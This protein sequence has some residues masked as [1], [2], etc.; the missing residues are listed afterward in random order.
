MNQSQKSKQ[1]QRDHYRLVEQHGPLGL[2]ILVMTLSLSACG[3]SE[4]KP[5]MM[6]ASLSG[7]TA[8]EVAGEAAGEVAGEAAGEVAGEA[9]GEVAGETAGEVAGETAG[10]VAGEMTAGEA[11]G[12]MAGEAAGEVTAGTE[13][14][15]SLCDRYCE[16]FISQCVDRASARWGQDLIDQQNACLNDCTLIED[17]E[18]GDR[19]GETVAC[20]LHYLSMTPDGDG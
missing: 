9:A 8:G 17:G 14:A 4:T 19:S 16:L 10:A 11:A 18:E 5:T 13:P 7:E 15:P 1:G 6:D 20:S 2:V 12:E 3:P